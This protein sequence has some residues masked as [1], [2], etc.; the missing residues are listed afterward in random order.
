MG[1]QELTRSADLFQRLLDQE[2]EAHAA[3]QHEVTQLQQ[4]VR[5][6]E[7]RLR[8]K[9]GEIEQLT[10]ADKQ[11]NAELSSAVETWRIARERC[12]KELES[13]PL[14]HCTEVV[15]RVATAEEEAGHDRHQTHAVAR[16]SN[17]NPVG[18][19]FEKP[20]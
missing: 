18:E 1:Q 20:A 14:G 6:L 8:T 19:T 10:R 13:G 9:A 17:I 11:A 5:D 12:S 4:V 2:S 16:Q 7:S 15:A 3:V